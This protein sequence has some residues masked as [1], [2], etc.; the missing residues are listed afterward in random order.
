VYQPLGP[1]DAPRDIVINDV[2]GLAPDEAQKTA[3]KYLGDEKVKA[4]I[5]N[6][7]KIISGVDGDETQGEGA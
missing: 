6:L 4:S 2:L 3:L 7:A 5:E 1:E